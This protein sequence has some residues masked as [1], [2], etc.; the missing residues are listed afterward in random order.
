MTL[1]FFSHVLAEIVFGDVGLAYHALDKMGVVF[2]HVLSE[3]PCW[4]KVFTHGA[5][6]VTGLAHF[7]HVLKHELVRLETFTSRHGPVNAFLADVVKEV[8]MRP[9]VRTR[10]MRAPVGGIV[11]IHER[12]KDFIRE[13]FRQTERV[14]GL[15]T[16][17]TPFREGSITWSLI[18]FQVAVGAL[19]TDHGQRR[20]VAFVVGRLEERAGK[21][22]ETDREQGFFMTNRTT[23]VLH[24]QKKSFLVF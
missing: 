10:E 12:V 7:V 3:F 17:K 20:A 13:F 14:H 18:Q 21:A 22:L 16:K 1:V 19:H 9:L 11:N 6:G 2:L 5:L 24:K 4:H 23:R 15:C 8:E